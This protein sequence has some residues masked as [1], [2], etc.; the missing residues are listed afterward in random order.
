MH[1]IIK[2][3][4]N[5]E[6]TSIN[7]FLISGR[8]P[9]KFY[10]KRGLRSIFEDP[11][12]TIIK[13]MEGPLGFKIRQ[14][15]YKNKMRYLGNNVLFDPDVSLSLN[16]S[17][18]IGDLS[19]IADGAQL[20]SPEGYIKIGKRCHIANRIL[21]HGGVEIGNCVAS[22]GIILSVTDT[23]YGGAR[24]AGP[25]IP[26][27]QRNLRYGKVTIEDD[28]FIG[29]YSIVMPGVTI[30]EGA[31]IGPHS[32]VIKNVKPWTVVM[33]SPAEEVSEREKVRFPKFD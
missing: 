22:V 5:N 21:G 13:Y 6:K 14:L 25:M 28:A 12:L 23:S 16:R 31:V 18:S 29:Q 10:I 20:Y 33:G 2:K 8:L 9:F 1:P 17:I 24:M 32:L 4:D 7:D 15:Y 27:E 3:R 30:G 19:R 26:A 11:L